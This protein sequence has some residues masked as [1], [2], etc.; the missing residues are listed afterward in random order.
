[1]YDDECR[2]RL[3]KR[4]LE[5]LWEPGTWKEGWGLEIREIINY[6]RIAQVEGLILMLSLLLTILWA[7]LGTGPNAIS[8]AMAAGQ[9]AF[10]AGNAL[11]FIIAASLQM[12]EVWKY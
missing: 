10:A 4:R 2:N 5:L 7:K 1:V 9:V 11:W 12:L 8:N 6:G 3:P